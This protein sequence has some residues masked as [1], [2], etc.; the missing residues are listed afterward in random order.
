MVLVGARCAF[1]RACVTLRRRIWRSPCPLQA[2]PT[3]TL[4][5]TVH[6]GESRPGFIGWDLVLEYCRRG[7]ATVG[8]GLVVASF[9]SLLGLFVGVHIPQPD[10]SAHKLCN[11]PRGGRATTRDASH[12]GL[13]LDARA[14]QPSSR[15]PIVALFLRAGDRDQGGRRGSP[16]SIVISRSR[17]FCWC[18]SSVLS[19][20]NAPL[21]SLHPPNTGGVG[22]LR[23]L[24]LVLTGCGLLFFSYNITSGFDAGGLD[25]CC[26]NRRIP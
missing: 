22:H 6:M 23:R 17:S 7:S 19:H 16:S 11:W 4:L 26:R 12:P 24:G 10:R 25:A 14:N 9:V 13:N 21:D 1:P 18:C 5:L 3:R 2:A 8:V 15:M 20:L